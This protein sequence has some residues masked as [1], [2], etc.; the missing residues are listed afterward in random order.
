MQ[1]STDRVL[2]THTGSL[3]RPAELLDLLIARDAGQP[4][5]AARFEASAAAAVVDV[6][7]RQF[8]A[9]LDVVNVGEMSKIG[10]GNY[11]KERLT[12]FDGAGQPRPESL[13]VRAFAGW[14]ARY[15]TVT[16]RT[17]GSCTGP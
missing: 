1:R 17:T 7:G 8:D 4:V 3:A 9:G 14:G 13:D 10:F 11:V 5:D 16:P 12:G 15:Q 2:T 6:V